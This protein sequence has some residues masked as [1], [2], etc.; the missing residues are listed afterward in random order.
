MRHIV[1][2]LKGW[3]VGSHTKSEFETKAALFGRT[4]LQCQ[5]HSHAEADAG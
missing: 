2:R 1:S 5:Q 3:K 4:H